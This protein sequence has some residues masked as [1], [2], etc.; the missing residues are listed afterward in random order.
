M[1]KLLPILAILATA[2]FCPPAM[3]VDAHGLYQ[4]FHLITCEAYAKDRKQ[5]ANTGMNAIDAIYVS[6]CLSAYNYLTP[7]NYQIV[8]SNNIGAVMQWLDEFC[9]NN[10]KSN[11]EIAMLKLT[12]DLYPHRVQELKD[13]NAKPDKKK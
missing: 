1:K 11:I 2:A 6:G 3:A 13:P 4:T 8:P 5:P 10:P 7:N 9:K 12:D